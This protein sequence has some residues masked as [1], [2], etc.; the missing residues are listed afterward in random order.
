ME[1]TVTE[2][3]LRT[4]NITE[5]LFWLVASAHLLTFLAITLLENNQNLFYSLNQ[6]ASYL[7]NTFWQV[8]THFGET[9]TAAAI[10]LLLVR[11]HPAVIP[12]ILISGGLCFLLVYGLK[13]YLDITRPHLVL[14]QD[15]FNFIETN[16]ASPARPSGHAA[17][18]AFIAGS[19]FYLCRNS[20]STCLLLVY[21]GVLVGLAR[22]A[23]GVHWPLD[24]ALGGAIGWLTGYIGFSFISQKLT[25]KEN[26]INNA[27]KIKKQRLIALMSIGLVLGL[28]AVISY[29]YPEVTVWFKGILSGCLLWVGYRVYKD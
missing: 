17:T 2:D 21:A 19:L 16:K 26:Q 8:T 24:V 18:G 12:H 7:P 23:I 6:T 28:L 25:G 22:I 3:R 27:I 14:A 9:L 15:S 11:R 20:L 1:A 29:P 13:Q 10:L 4:S 5:K